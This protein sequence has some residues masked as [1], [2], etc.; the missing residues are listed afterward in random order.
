METVSNKFYTTV[1]QCDKLNFELMDALNNSNMF[2]V[3][4]VIRYSYKHM[5]AIL[6]SAKCNETLMDT[7]DKF[8]ELFGGQHNELRAYATL[9]KVFNRYPVSYQETIDMCTNS[10]SLAIGISLKYDGLNAID[11]VDEIKNYLTELHEVL[12]LCSDLNKVFITRADFNVEY[13]MFYKAFNMY[14]DFFLN[15]IYYIYNIVTKG[16]VSIQENVQISETHELNS[17]YLMLNEYQ[18]VSEAF[19]LN[20]LMDGFKKIIDNIIA[21][22]KKIGFDFRETTENAKKWR[23]ANGDIL[24]DKVEFTDNKKVPDKETDL[25]TLGRL[26]LNYY[27]K[28][29][30]ITKSI[31]STSTK[32]YNKAPKI[33]SVSNLTNL[34]NDT[35]EMLK[36]DSDLITREM[37]LKDLGIANKD[38]TSKSLAEVIRLYVVEKSEELRGSSFTNSDLIKHYLST[39]EMLTGLDKLTKRAT[40]YIDK[41]KNNVDSVAR[42]VKTLQDKE[43]NKPKE[44]TKPNTE[45]DSANKPGK[46]TEQATKDKEEQVKPNA[47]KNDGTSGDTGMVLERLDAITENFTTSMNIIIGIT[48][49]NHTIVYTTIKD[50]EKYFGSLENRKNSDKANVTSSEKDKEEDKTGTDGKDSESLSNTKSRSVDGKAKLNAKDKML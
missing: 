22:A 31:I 16:N 7:Y 26:D 14:N 37:I 28:E 21:L 40:T 13:E 1:K 49:I 23:A 15:E 9:L 41:Y 27:D 12:L 4:R 47:D 42:Q 50:I 5:I 36:D 6:K 11:S 19:G 29:N 30:K 34:I 3:R 32:F 24:N 18:I 35:E 38:D 33:A 43:K 25:N 8:G 10:S 45:V 17:L 2:G 44:D 46:S 39:A 48:Q 20:L